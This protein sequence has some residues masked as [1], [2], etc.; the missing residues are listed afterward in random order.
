M[1]ISIYFILDYT[2][3]T[4]S[5][6][7]PDQKKKTILKIKKIIKINQMDETQCRCCLAE[8]SNDAVLLLNRVNGILIKD[9]LKIVCGIDVSNF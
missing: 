7:E 4:F 2:A 8:L 3:F 5:E 9:Q 6:P 1:Q